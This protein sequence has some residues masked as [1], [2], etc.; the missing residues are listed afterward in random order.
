VV[1]DRM[2]AGCSKNLCH[3]S[4]VCCDVVVSW[5]WGI[6]RVDRYTTFWWQ[7]GYLSFGSVRWCVRSPFP[8]LGLPYISLHFVPSHPIPCFHASLSTF[9]LFMLQSSL[10]VSL[11]SNFFP[12][13][14]LQSSIPLIKFCQSV[15]IPC[16]AM[17]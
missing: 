7:K 16:Y 9:P 8:S 6:I 17:Q 3:E 1:M 14:I 13:P 10:S 11:L 5:S 12:L 15:P 4:M 2:L